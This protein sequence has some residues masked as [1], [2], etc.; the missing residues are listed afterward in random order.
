MVVAG[1]LADGRLG[2]RLRDRGAA[3]VEVTAYRTVEGPPASAAGIRAALAVGLD[4]LV[5]T[6]GSTVRGLLAL[7]EGPDRVAI[8]D[9]PAFCIG[10]STAAVARGAGFAAVHEASAPDPTTLAELVRTTLAGPAGATDER[11]PVTV[12]GEVS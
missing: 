2:D 1:D 9:A 8:L 6:S 11:P 10:P 12:T 7:L 5:F 4:G 3:V